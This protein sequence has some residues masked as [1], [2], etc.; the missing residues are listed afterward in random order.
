[1]NKRVFLLLTMLMF[2]CS[3]PVE[4]NQ[5]M[6]IEINDKGEMIYQH[7][8]ISAS[9]LA[10]KRSQGISIIIKAREPQKNMGLNNVRI[11]QADDKSY[12]LE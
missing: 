11:Q 6:E 1:M 4:Q 10:E 2:G 9:E 5:A 3:K 7:K 8:V 12:T